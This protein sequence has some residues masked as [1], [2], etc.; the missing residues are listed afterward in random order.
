ME[1]WARLPSRIRMPLLQL[2]PLLRRLGSSTTR[3]TRLA[4]Q[5]CL[6][7]CLLLRRMCCQRTISIMLTCQ[8]CMRSSL[9]LPGSQA[10]QPS[11]SLDLRPRL[12][13]SLLRPRCRRQIWRPSRRPHS[14]WATSQWW[15][16]QVR[17]ATKLIASMSR[18]LARVEPRVLS[19]GMPSAVRLD[20]TVSLMASEPPPRSSAAA[21]A[22][23]CLSVCLLSLHCNCVAGF[24]TSVQPALI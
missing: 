17:S 9:T 19:Y 13:L 22:Q 20:V 6:L 2:Q 4:C 18:Y 3:W 5:A 15:S 16:R 23:C 11:L 24:G 1:A 7:L 21:C 10:Q 14:S 8:L 12:L